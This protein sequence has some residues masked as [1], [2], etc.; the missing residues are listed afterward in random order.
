MNPTLNGI[1]IVIAVAFK[2][3]LGL[4]LALVSGFGLEFFDHVPGS[5]TVRRGWAGYVTDRSSI[6]PFLLDFVLE[7]CVAHKTR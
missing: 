5:G 1:G 3:C 6:G 4:I 2:V 7:F